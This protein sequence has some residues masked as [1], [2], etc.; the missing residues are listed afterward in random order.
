[1]RKWKIKQTIKIA[2]S[3]LSL[4]YKNSITPTT[5]IELA[6]LMTSLRHPTI[7]IFPI[8]SRRVKVG[9]AQAL[10]GWGTFGNPSL[11]YP[12]Q[13]AQLHRKSF[14]N[15]NS[16]IQPHSRP[17]KLPFW[18]WGPCIC[19]FFFLT[20]WLQC[21]ARVGKNTDLNTSKVFQTIRFANI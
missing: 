5:W 8:L 6:L 4:F 17:I 10:V 20:I 13:A 11:S 9:L 14:V 2:T 15:K 12:I 21:V 3:V 16:H 18:R 19:I 7:L 1:M